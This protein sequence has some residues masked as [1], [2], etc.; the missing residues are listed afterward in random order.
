MLEVDCSRFLI[1][2]VGYLDELRKV[3]AEAVSEFFSG[4]EVE[5]VGHVGEDDRSG[6]QMPF[7]LGPCDVLF[8]GEL[9]CFD[10][11]VLAI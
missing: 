10:D 1:E 4:D 5:H 2:K 11:E 8:D 6:W 7:I 3:A 9:G